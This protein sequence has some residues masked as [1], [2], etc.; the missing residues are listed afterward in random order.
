[1]AESNKSGLVN[2]LVLITALVTLATAALSLYT[3]WRNS[4]NIEAIHISINSRMDELLAV[5]R[6]KARAEGVIEGEAR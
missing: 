1:M 5:T 6:Q 3:S 2:A 4:E